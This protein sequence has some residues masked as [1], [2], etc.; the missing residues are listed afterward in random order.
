MQRAYFVHISTRERIFTYFLPAHAMPSAPAA[1]A[2]SP[3]T[4]QSAMLITATFAL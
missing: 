1:A 2:M 4:C 3:L